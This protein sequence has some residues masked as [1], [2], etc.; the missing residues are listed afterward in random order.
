MLYS[1]ALQE[2]DEASKWVHR[3]EEFCDR[4]VILVISSTSWRFR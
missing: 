1:I 3:H 2:A 4:R